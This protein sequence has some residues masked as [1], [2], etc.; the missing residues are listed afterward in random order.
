[1]KINANFVIAAIAMSLIGTSALA[2]DTPVT[3][4]SSGQQTASRDFGK[5]SIDGGQA[6]RDLRLARLAIFDGKTAQSKTLLE[7]ARTALNK[8]KSAD[9]VF[10]KAEADLKPG[11]GMKQN[12]PEDKKPGT[13]P[14]AWIPVDGQMT[15]AEDYVASPEKAAGVAKADTELKS[16]RKTAALDTLKLANVDVYFVEE[17]APLDATISG[18]D[19]ALQ[20]VDQGHYYEANQVLKSVEDGIRFDSDMLSAR[21]DKAVAAKHS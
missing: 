12:A 3:P 8:A 18:V 1:V 21:P 17:V 9:S 14:V 15:L 19:K 6:V 7:G 11:P 16:G 2:A 5:L 10:T 13:T 20:L 4:P